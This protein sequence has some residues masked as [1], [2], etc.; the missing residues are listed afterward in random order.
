MMFVV[1]RSMVGCV[2]KPKLAT[3]GRPSYTQKMFFNHQR[4]NEFTKTWER[5][6]AN[7]M[8]MKNHGYHVPMF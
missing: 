8:E 3:G 6:M 5:D 1:D 7:T 2:P 4:E